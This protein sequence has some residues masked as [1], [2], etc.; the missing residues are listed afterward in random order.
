MKNLQS[1]FRTA[2]SALR[3]TGFFGIVSSTL[4]NKI[5]VFISGMILVRVI[6]KTEYGA[7]SYALNIINYFV[8]FNGLGTSS[9]VVQY[10]VEQSNA[11][12]AER[13]YS[14]LCLLGMLWDVLLTILIVLVALFVE[15]PIDG[16]NRL[17]LFLAPYPILSLAVELQQ[18]RLRSLFK[19]SEYAWA[20]NINTILVVIASIVGAVLLSSVG[21]TVGRTLAMLAS[22]LVVWKLFHIPIK[23]ASTHADKSIIFDMLKMSVTVCLTNLVS[24]AL[25]LLGTTLSGSLIADGSAVATY[26][27]ATTIP[28]ALSFIPSM[29]LVY[30]SPYFIRHSHDRGWVLRNWLYCAAGIGVIC[31]GISLIGISL[32]GLII[33]A[34]FGSRYQ[35]AIPSYNV[36]MVAFAIGSPLRTVAGS[37]LATHR[38]YISNFISGSLSVILCFVVSALL[39]PVYGIVG[40]AYGYLASMIIGSLYNVIAMFIFAGNPVEPPS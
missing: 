30:A 8:L 5:L 25:M 16:S 13:A 11:S 10:C 28:F 1:Q 39:I 34:L 32:S 36:L 6:S 37:V 18:Q 38:K 7:Y 14:M 22:V 20:T 35:G 31:T 23:L 29:V 17:L 2:V 9:C 33:P 26:S 21:L 19:N 15:L 24:Q 3:K 4:A 27:T 12:K 40:A